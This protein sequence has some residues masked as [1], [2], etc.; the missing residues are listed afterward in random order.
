[1]SKAGIL[2]LT[3]SAAQECSAEGIRINALVPGGF[4]IDSLVIEAVEESFH[5][6]TQELIEA[7]KQSGSQDGWK[8]MV[9][10]YLSIERCDR[11]EIGCPIA[12]LA[13]DIARATP[14]IKQRSSAAIL[15]FRSELIPHMPGKSTDEKAS[16]FLTIMTSMVGASSIARTM[17]DLAVQQRILNTVRDRLLSSL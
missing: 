11:P 12:A 14:V 16:N 3:K 8:S 10:T 7:A 4:D 9:R 1:M 17:P 15:K 2:T 6:L 5:E 13:P